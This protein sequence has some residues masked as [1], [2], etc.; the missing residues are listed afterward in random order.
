MNSNYNLARIKKKSMDTV[1]VVKTYDDTNSV[2]IVSSYCVDGNGMEL[3]EQSFFI[4]VQ[5]ISSSEVDG[6]I[7][8]DGDFSENG[9]TIR[10][11]FS[12]LLHD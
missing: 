12:E 4:A 3:A 5:N 11:I 7:H 10:M 2:D 8:Q 9:V 1:S 6:S